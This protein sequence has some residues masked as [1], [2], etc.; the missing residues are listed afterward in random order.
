[1]G[2]YPVA[3]VILHVY[4]MWHWLLLN[5]SRELNLRIIITIDSIQF[6]LLITSPFTS[7]T[8]VTFYLSPPFQAH[9]FPFRCTFHIRSTFWPP[10]FLLSNSF[11]VMHTA[12][13]TSV[14]KYLKP[15]LR[16]PRSSHSSLTVRGSFCLPPT[17]KTRHLQQLPWGR[18]VSN[19]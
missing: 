15:Y 2:W 9:R 5:L 4:R 12:A 1:M 3:V 7:V 11:P 6:V 13:A 8:F 16:I 14:P 19:L 18:A 10:S 17:R